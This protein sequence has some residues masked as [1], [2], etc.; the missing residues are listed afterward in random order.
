MKTSTMMPNQ[1]PFRA[2][3]RAWFAIATLAFTATASA[4]TV[5]FDT[6][7][8]GGGGFYN[9]SDLAGGFTIGGA[10]F[11][12]NFT[13]F[14]GG[15]C[16]DGWSVS[17]HGDTTTP[18]FGNQYSSYTGGGVGGGGQFGVMYTDSANI[19]LATA[20]TV[21]GTYLTNTTYAAL[22]M[23]NGD[24]F[25]KQF[26][27][28]TGTDA[29]WFSVTIEGLLSGGSTGS[30]EFFLADYRFANSLDDYIIDEWTWVDLS[31]LGVVDELQFSFGSS[32][33]G[34]FGINTPTYAAV[35]SFTT[36]PVPEPGTGLLCGIG[37][38]M[39]AGRSR[40]SRKR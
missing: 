39:M 30:V 1:T 20:E 36:M 15:C 33:V 29:D 31:S 11:N 4:S 27:G 9:G 38:A 2:L 24:G 35:D 8:V 32:D 23:L 21:T 37:L 13:D 40:R 17:N 6:F 25:A 28:A 5:T 14:G 19:T 34:A 12:N 10:T 7:P 16:W 3:A 18:G 22:S 26:G